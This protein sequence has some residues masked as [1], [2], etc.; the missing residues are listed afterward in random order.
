[1]EELQKL[2]I[3]QLN[4][5]EDLINGKNIFMSGPG[6]T[7]KSFLIEIIK[8]ICFKTNKICQLT[9]LTGCAALLINA[10]TIHSWSGIGIIKNDEI[11][12]TYY[13]NKIRK[14]KKTLNWIEV[15]CLVIDEVSM[16]SKKFFD[17]LDLI[18]KKIRKNDKPFGGIQI[19]LS[20]DFYQLPPVNKDKLDTDSSLFCFQSDKWNETFSTIHILTKI[21]RQ[22]NKIFSKLL[23]NIRIG[24]ITQS[25]I[26]ILNSR[27]IPYEGNEIIPTKLFPKIDNVNQINNYEHEKLPGNGN[28]YKINIVKPSNEEMFENNITSFDIKQSTDL[29]MKNNL[30]IEF[31]I[32]D[33]VI[34]TYNIS[35]KIVNGSRGIIVGFKEFPI[36]KF[37][38]GNILEMKPID[39]YDN[40][41]PGLYYKKIP[42]EYAWAL[43]IHKCQGM[44]LDL[45]IMDLGENIFEAGQMYVALSRVKSLEGLYLIDFHV[46]KIK[47]LQKVKVFYSKYPDKKYDKEER[48]SEK[49]RIIKLIHEYIETNKNKRKPEKEIIVNNDLLNKLKEYRINKAKEK[50]I[51]SYIIFSDDTLTNIAS[52]IP[53][54]KNDL[55]NIRGIGKKKLEMYGEDILNITKLF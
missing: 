2:D 32:G 28:I 20:G 55:L 40:N 5:L 42:L 13:I 34:C 17:I 26:D 1:M 23:N 16:L 27:M 54:D 46:N 51:Q 9:A 29:I 45:C 10:K 48:K 12:V 33:Q 8:K 38:D 25:N 35:D 53:K 36:V 11:D 18:A 39:I 47:T 37:V 7:G 44:T 24:N 49:K 41:V 43:T 50:N 22:D 15:E 31:K 19:I 14:H 52:E 6:G 21:F 3:K 4:I 30:P